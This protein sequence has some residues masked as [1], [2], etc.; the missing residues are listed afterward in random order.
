M[1]KLLVFKFSSPRNV[2]LLP[3]VILKLISEQNVIPQKSPVSYRFIEIYSLYCFSKYDHI[4]SVFSKWVR[5]S[6]SLVLKPSNPSECNF[7]LLFRLLSRS[8]LANTE[9]DQYPWNHYRKTTQSQSKWEWKAIDQPKSFAN[10]KMLMKCIRNCWEYSY[11]RTNSYLTIPLVG[12][13]LVNSCTFVD[14]HDG[15]CRKSLV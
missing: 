3:K 15:K 8:F 2:T 11:K 14:P 12:I 7:Y 1:I 4:K 5:E 6:G 10:L 9:N 13:W